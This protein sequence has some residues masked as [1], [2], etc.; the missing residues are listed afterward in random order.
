MSRKRYGKKY[1]KK[2]VTRKLKPKV[3]KVSTMNAV[4]K[5]V[6]DSS[7]AKK[8]VEM[9]FFNNYELSFDGA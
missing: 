6:Y 9:N 3:S 5:E 8:K 2:R 7:S 1:Q 4:A